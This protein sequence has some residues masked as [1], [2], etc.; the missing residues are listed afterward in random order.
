MTHV[1]MLHGWGAA[2]SVWR[3]QIKAFKGA[4]TVHAPTL[5]RWEAAWV[6]DFLGK[7][8]LS[9]TVAV[10]WSLGGMLLLEALIKSQ[11]KPAGLILVGVPA[12]FCRS[13]DHPWGQHP[14]AVRAMRRAL[15]HAA[16]QVL[17]D[18]ARGC[19]AP[20]EAGF[21]DEVKALFQADMT[22]AHLAAGLDYL[23]TTDLRARLPELAARPV[24][25]QGE[26]DS[27]VSLKQA[28]FLN[29]HLPNSRLITLAGAGHLPFI[30][31]AARFDEILREVVGGGPGR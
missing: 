8:P 22:E 5:S 6:G 13:E 3:R 9:H 25:V 2:G 21:G 29:E 31:Q 30:T 26:E 23:L 20:E 27:I 17:E 16:S 14:A 18:F 24:I 4:C 10:G 19:L 7:M 28:H 1:V 12:D 15:K 11:E